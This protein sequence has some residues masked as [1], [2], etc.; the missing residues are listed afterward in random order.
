MSLT[1]H[2]QNGVVVFDIPNTLPDGTAVKIEA[3][4]PPSNGVLDRL[5]NVG[6]T[7]EEWRDDPES[8][9]AW[10]AGVRSIERPEYAAEERAD[11]ARYREEYR[12]YSCSG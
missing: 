3:I 1:G 4:E 8:I 2:V 7:E 12:R 10:I 11:M 5:G 6:L 9:A